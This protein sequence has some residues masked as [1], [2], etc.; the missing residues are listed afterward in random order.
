[1][2][3]LVAVTQLALCFVFVFCNSGDGQTRPPEL[4]GQWEHASGATSGKPEKLELFK[5]GTG[6]VD[7][8]GSVTW[9]VENKRFVILS[10]LFALSCN[11][12][13]SGYELSLAYDDGTSAIFVR[14][15]KLEEYK[16]KQ[17]AAAEA[18]KAKRIAETKQVAEKAKAS[19]GTFK[20]SRDGK[21]YKTVKVG[22]KTWMAENLNF[23]ADGSKCY[24]NNAGNCEKYGRLYTWEAAKKACPAGW[25]LPSDAEWTALT[26]A[27]GGGSVAGTKLKS[28]SGWANNGNGTDEYG[29]AALP[30]GDGNSDGNFNDAGNIGYWWSSTEYD[31]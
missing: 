30:G 8:K 12:K 25:H 27:V 10:P 11:Y 28:N 24:E 20:D 1:M 6:V 22:G 15:G 16:A 4:A 7:S 18:E 14:K 9:K 21:T 3:K 26:D 19:A 13:V 31:A 29:F 17:A 5:D 2:N 23:A